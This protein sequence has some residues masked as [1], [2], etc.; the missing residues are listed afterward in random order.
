[1]TKTHDSAA[2][3]SDVFERADVVADAVNVVTLREE[4]EHWLRHRFELDSLRL[5]DVVLAVNEALANVAEFAY[6][7][8]DQTGTVDIRAEYERATSILTITVTDYGSW[9]DSSER[10]PRRTR[11]RGIP[12]MEAL[13]DEVGIDAG[14]QGTTVCMRFGNISLSAS[15]NG[16]EVATA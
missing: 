16:D 14:A 11:G 8:C 10:E 5:N 15:R 3:E 9:R 13:S 12:L 2:S 6:R 7:H 1:M 4:L